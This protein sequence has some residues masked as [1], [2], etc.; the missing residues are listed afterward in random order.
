MVIS[1]GIANSN[2]RTQN[3]EL[4]TQN[5]ERRTKTAILR[6]A[7]CALSSALSVA[8]FLHSRHD[9]VH[10]RHHRLFEVMVEGHGD[11]VAVDVFDGGVEVV[12]GRLLDLL[13]NAGAHAA[14]AP[15][16]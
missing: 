5:S 2:R 11:L 13:Q 6:S 16:F 1:A 14:V 10:A 8:H 4:R 7:F 9:P 12:E 15:V 3:S